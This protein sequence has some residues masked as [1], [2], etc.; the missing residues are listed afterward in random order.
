MLDQTEIQE[1]IE[2]THVGS[3]K[4][5]RGS[6]KALDYYVLTQYIDKHPELEQYQDEIFLW[7]TSDHDLHRY[8]GSLKLEA[9]RKHKAVQLTK[10]NN[11]EFL[12]ALES[13]PSWKHH[14]NRNQRLSGLL[15]AFT[16]IEK[17][18]SKQIEMSLSSVSKMLAEANVSHTVVSSNS[19]TVALIGAS[20][21][22]KLINQNSESDDKIKA[23]LSKYIFAIIHSNTPVDSKTIKLAYSSLLALGNA[24]FPKPTLSQLSDHTTRSYYTLVS[25]YRVLSRQDA[26]KIAD[27]APDDAGEFIIDAASNLLSRKSTLRKLEAER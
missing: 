24:L 20:N 2:S 4:E 12:D 13:T 10:D 8:F 19:L 14:L 21:L 15:K 27:A 22:A 17:S 18:K 23:L 25:K 9:W 6:E 11:E 16:K 26:N 7:A 1:A 5:V 3:P